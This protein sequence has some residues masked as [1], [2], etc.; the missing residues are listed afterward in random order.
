M[1]SDIE[2]ILLQGQDSIRQMLYKIFQNEL[3]FIELIRS[4]KSQPEALVAIAQ[5]VRSGLYTIDAM[6]DSI[7]EHLHH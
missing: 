6:G 7:Q 2:K 5:N 4:G 3:M 1:T